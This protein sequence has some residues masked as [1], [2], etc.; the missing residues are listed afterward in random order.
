MTAPI[1][2]FLAMEPQIQM[3]YMVG[4]RTGIF[5][6]L[7]DLDDAEL[8][9]HAEKALAAHRVTRDNVNEWTAEMMRRFI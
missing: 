9:A 5:H 2:S 1:R 7:A 3:L 4:R 8:R 6:R